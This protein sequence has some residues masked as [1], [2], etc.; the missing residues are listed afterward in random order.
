[1]SSHSSK[2]EQTSK[3][4][5]HTFSP[6]RLIIGFW[7]LLLN[8]F[9][10]IQKNIFKTSHLFYVFS[11]KFNMKNHSHSKWIF[12]FI[13]FF[14]RKLILKEKRKYSVCIKW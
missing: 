11:W 4:L 8:G 1:M 10:T 14:F 2:N 6:V 12:Y 9:K 13:S 7:K 3:Y 5:F